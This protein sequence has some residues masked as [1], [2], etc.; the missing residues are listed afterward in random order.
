[1]ILITG[2]LF[3]DLIEQFTLM[4]FYNFFN[5]QIYF[6]RDCYIFN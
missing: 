4:K 1:M 2:D 5:N 6:N 3:I